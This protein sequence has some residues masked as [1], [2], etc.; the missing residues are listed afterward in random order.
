MHIFLALLGFPKL[1]LFYIHK[2]W[3]CTKTADLF[4]IFLYLTE[5]MCHVFCEKE[6]TCA[7][8]PEK[9]EK[10]KV[11]KKKYYSSSREYRCIFWRLWGNFQEKLSQW[12]RTSRPHLRQYFLAAITIHLPFM[13][14]IV[15]RLKR[16][17]CTVWADI[18]TTFH[19]VPL[20][21]QR[22][23]VCLPIVQ[24][25]TIYFSS[26]IQLDVNVTF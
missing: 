1:F 13:Y 19:H 20:W 5:S 11:W 4:Q 3:P 14:C 6:A 17:S 12:K 22:L 10:M 23:C 15:F 9:R 24:G 8:M 25:K 26:H 18:H 7:L 2:N 16:L 21:W